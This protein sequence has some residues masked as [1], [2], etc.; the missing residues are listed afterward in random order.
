MPYA[1][2]ILFT[3]IFTHGFIPS[4]MID[5]V[6]V[7]IIKNKAGTLADKNNY[8]STGI[9]SVCSKIL[10]RII[11]DR[12]ERYVVITDNQVGFKRCHSTETSIFLLKEIL[13]YFKRNDT[14]SF[15]CFMDASKAFDR[16]NHGK[17]LN[18]LQEYDIPPYILR[19]LDF[20]L[21]HQQL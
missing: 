21:S 11:L 7:P 15:L 20:W 4:K 8:R 10:E 9:S 16:I 6:L 1:S 5:S 12:I 14:T 3:S 19:I 13:Q 2:F 18:I 17:L